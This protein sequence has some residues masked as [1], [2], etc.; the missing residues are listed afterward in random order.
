M[1]LTRGLGLNSLVFFGKFARIVEHL[2]RHDIARFDPAFRFLFIMGPNAIPAFLFGVVAG[3]RNVRRVENVDVVATINFQQVSRNYGS[4]TSNLCAMS[5]NHSR[6]AAT[7]DRAAAG[8]QRK[9]P[10]D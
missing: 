3:V 1:Q 9:Q 4:G 2:L 7:G 8:K 5:N 6:I 10:N